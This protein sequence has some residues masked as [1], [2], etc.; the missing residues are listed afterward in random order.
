MKPPRKLILRGSRIAAGRI[1]MAMAA[2]QLVE[3]G[4]LSL[5]EDVNL[6]LKSWKVSENQFT[7]EQKVTLRRILTHTAGTTIHGF[8]G[9]EA[10]TPL[11][12]SC[13]SIANIRRSRRSTVFHN[14]AK[15]F[16]SAS[17]ASPNSCKCSIVRSECS[18]TV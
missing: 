11:P 1:L 4:K 8:L 12:T 6:K 10:G 2:L 13:R 16:P 7:R 15:F 5:D 3:Q 9:Y 18:S 17:A 14:G